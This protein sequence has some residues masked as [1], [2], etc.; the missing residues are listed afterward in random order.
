M[1]LVLC[2]A[3]LARSLNRESVPRFICLVSEALLVT[4]DGG[5]GT[6]SERCNKGRVVWLL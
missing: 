6:T 4:L 1:L 2:A 5:P 3:R